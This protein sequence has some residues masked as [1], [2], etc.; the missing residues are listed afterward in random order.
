MVR[1]KFSDDG[2]VTANLNGDDFAENLR[3][4]LSGYVGKMPDTATVVSIRDRVPATLPNGFTGPV[5]VKQDPVDPTKVNVTLTAPL[6]YIAGTYAVTPSPSDVRY[7]R[8]GSSDENYWRLL[9]SVARTPEV[10]S[11]GWGFAGFRA[12]LPGRQSR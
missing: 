12:Y 7:A 9:R 8:G 1:V 5:D 11:K 2:A 6:T 4:A 10:P 3:E